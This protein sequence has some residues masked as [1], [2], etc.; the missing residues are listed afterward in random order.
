MSKSKTS[1]A[2]ASSVA[3]TSPPAYV[4]GL[5]F[6]NVNNEVLIIDFVD[7]ADGQRGLS[8][9]SSVAITPH[10]AKQMIDGLTTFVGKHESTEES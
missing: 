9:F 1:Q 2:D 8:I 3:R 10:T 6:G 5:R 7:V 4:T